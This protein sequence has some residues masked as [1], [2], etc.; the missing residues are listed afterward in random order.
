MGGWVYMMASKPRGTLYTGVT[1]ELVHRAWQHREGE[2]P[3]FTSKYRVHL[4]VWY[5]EH[6]DIRNAIQRE[7]TIKPGCDSGSSISSRA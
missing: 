6:P 3:G 4:L 7:K 5:E 2:I 1:S